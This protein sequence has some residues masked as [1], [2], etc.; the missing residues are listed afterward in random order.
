MSLNSGPYSR[1]SPLFEKK[2]GD[3][4]K[5]HQDGRVVKALHLSCN[6]HTSSWVQT[7]LLVYNLRLAEY[8]SI[9]GNL[10]LR[11]STHSQALSCVGK[12]GGRDSAMHSGLKSS[13]LKSTESPVV[14]QSTI[15]QA[16]NT[17]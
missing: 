2:H 6:G 14:A 1:L 3:K 4:C 13:G 12:A 5:C 11:L 8:I 9:K 7:P 17:H 10:P 16:H 15:Q